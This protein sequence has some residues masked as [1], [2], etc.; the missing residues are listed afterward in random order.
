[1]NHVESNLVFETTIGEVT[2]S[3]ESSNKDVVSNEGIVRRQQVDVTLQ[4]TVT[5]S[6]GSYKKAKVYD[7]TVLKQE[8]QTISQ[9]KKL[10]TEGFVITTG[11]AV[12]YT[13][14]KCGIYCLWNGKE[15]SRWFLFI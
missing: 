14:L 1:M 10:P 9:I 6:V 4:I 5:F 15:C 2:L 11:I 13:H 12:S 7:V 8:L 3:Y